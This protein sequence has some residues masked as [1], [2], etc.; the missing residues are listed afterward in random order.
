[1]R[2]LALISLAAFAIAA[3]RSIA[4]AEPRSERRLLDV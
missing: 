2:L 3:E 1:L 4:Y